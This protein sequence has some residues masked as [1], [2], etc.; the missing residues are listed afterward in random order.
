MWNRYNKQVHSS[1]KIP[2]EKSITSTVFSIERNSLKR[3]TFEKTKRNQVLT[4]NNLKIQY[5][6]FKNGK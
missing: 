5:K 2:L 1:K 6:N 4:A 3:F